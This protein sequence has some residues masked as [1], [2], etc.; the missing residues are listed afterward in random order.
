MVGFY[1]SFMKMP[2]TLH[3][4]ALLFVKSEAFFLEGGGIDMWGYE[5]MVHTVHQT[6]LVL[7]AV[8]LPPERRHG[9]SQREGI[10]LLE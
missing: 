7:W 4:R 1:L 10:S 6:V 2:C 8:A 9:S 5:I 3:S